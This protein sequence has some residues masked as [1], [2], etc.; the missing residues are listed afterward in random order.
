MACFLVDGSGDCPAILNAP[1]P[2]LAIYRRLG[3]IIKQ[4]FTVAVIHALASS[5][6]SP[7]RLDGFHP[8]A[9]P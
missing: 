8:F 5:D 1:S 6:R 4:S 2:G 7:A 9:G 3:G